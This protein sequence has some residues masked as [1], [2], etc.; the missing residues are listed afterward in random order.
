MEWERPGFGRIPLHA[1][2]RLKYDG[3]P[4]ISEVPNWNPDFKGPV[5]LGKPDQW[6]DR[7]AFVLPLQ[8][9]FGNVGRSPLRGPGL[10]MV[11]T[12][13]LKKVRISERLNLQFRAE[14]FNVLNHPNFGYRNE[15]LFQG[16]EYS[17]SGGVITA[18]ATTSR[19]IQFALKLLF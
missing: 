5:I 13:L 12:S 14:A 15:V 3:D 18:T 7:R 19:Q 6:F 1:A 17:P 2:D 9:T 16:T 10:F 4:S 8:G 11:D